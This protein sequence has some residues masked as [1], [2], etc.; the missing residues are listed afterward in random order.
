[1]SINVIGNA[2]DLIIFVKKKKTFLGQKK[3][4]FRKQIKIVII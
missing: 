4:Q 3:I 1:M 2:A